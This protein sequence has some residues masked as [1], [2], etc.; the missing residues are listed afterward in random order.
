MRFEHVPRSTS[1]L[2]L[3]QLSNQPIRSEEQ[4]YS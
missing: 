4:V 2:I 3:Q 1:L